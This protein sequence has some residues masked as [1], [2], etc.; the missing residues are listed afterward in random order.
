MWKRF[1]EQEPVTPEVEEGVK[2]T[3]SELE[4][5]ADVWLREDSRRELCRKCD[6]PGSLTGEV[7]TKKQSA[8]DKQGTELTLEFNQYRCD[9]DHTWYKGEGKM[10]G[11]AGENPILFEEHFQSRK[12]REIYTARGTPD[13]NIV[14]G[15]YNRTHPQGRKVNS[16]EQRQKNGASYY[17]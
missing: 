1:E 3:P 6:Q 12:R 11:I 5:K 2:Y 7:K 8:K 4:A 9:N 14:S 17:R 15:S 16:L 10:R 13:P